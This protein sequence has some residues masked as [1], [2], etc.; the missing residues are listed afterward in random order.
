MGEVTGV[1]PSTHTNGAPRFSVVDITMP[2]LSVPEMLDVCTAVGAQGLAIAER[3]LGDIER[4]AELIAASGLAVTGCFSRC[5]SILPPAAAS[6][7]AAMLPELDT[8]AKR[9]AAIA[10]SMRALA[11]LAPGGFFIITGPRGGYSAA[12]ADA[13][14][15][16]GLRELAD[17]AAEIGSGVNLELFHSSLADWS[18]ASSVAEGVALLDQVGRP[19]AKLAV[20]IWHLADGPETLAQLRAHAGRIASVHIDDRRDPTRSPRDRVYPG[21]GV[22][23][24]AG[25][26]GAIDAG[27][28]RGWYELEI[29]SDD[30]RYADEFPDSL[31]KLDPLE[32]V[33]TGRAKFEAAWATRR[34]TAG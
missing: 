6:A 24:V 18:Y 15:V 9:V 32:L 16:E 11:P 19:N 26:L 34:L 22:A 8:P 25:I 20:D 33:R 7:A 3:R 10:D 2:A 13:L 21:D 23:D 1:N 27:G 28:Y 12:E 29:I 4:D 31:W 5:T 30:G 14:A 17:V